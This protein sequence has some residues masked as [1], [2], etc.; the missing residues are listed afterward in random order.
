MPAKNKTT[1]E[2]TSDRELVVKRSFDGPARIVFEAWTTPELLLRWW[3]PVSFGISFVSCE[4]DVRAGGKYRFVFSHPQAPEPMAFYG[5]YL[6]VV[7]PSRLVWTNEEAGEAGQVTTA[8]FTE[9]GKQ[10]HLVMHD[11]YPSKEA[12]DEALASGSTGGSPETFD[13]LDEL[14][15]TLPA[16]AE[17]A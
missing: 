9:E 14:L 5:R 8:T 1:T 7:P 11:L 12:L 6:E 10:T 15:A 2:R 16:T 4:A 13:Q 3:A 17:R